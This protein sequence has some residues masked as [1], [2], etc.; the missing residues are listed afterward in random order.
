[1]IDTLIGWVLR[2][3]LAALGVWALLA[4]VRWIR[5]SRRERREAWTLR[6]A[7]GMV[8]LAAVYAAGHARLLLARESIEEGRTRYARFGDPRLAESNRAETRGWILDCSGEDRAALAR[9]AERGGVVERR[10]P[11]GQAGANLVGGGSEATERDFTVERLFAER[12]RRPRSLMES[13]ELHPAGTDL[14]LSLCAEPT[15]EAW[16]LLRGTGRPGTVVVQ[17]VG[18]GAL[19]AYAATGGPEQAPLGIKRYAPP[20]SVFKLALAALWWENGL[21]DT[22]LPCPA[23]IQVTPRAT[24]ANAGRAGYG[25]VEGP[26]GMLIPSCNTTAVIMAQRM[27]EQLGEEAFVQAYR[28]FGFGPYTGDAPRGADTAF[29][30]SGSDAWIRRMSPSLSRIRIGP[31]TGPAEW[32]QLAI[33]Q[34][35]VDVTPIAISR[36]VQAI[37]NGGVMLPPAL[38]W[39]RARK[40]PEGERV[41]SARTA[42]RLQRA[43]RGVVERGTG[44]AAAAQVRGVPGTLGG[45]TGTA[46]VRGAPDDGWFAGLVFDAEGRPRYT[47][48][49]YL[50]GGGPGGRA[51][52]QVAGGVARILLVGEG[53]R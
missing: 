5:D 33:G 40:A 11:L 19:V 28:R 15:R 37:G 34:G 35:P 17:D 51:P 21:P 46:Q 49:V 47:V 2:G 24:I 22:P 31:Q 23:E 38:E 13:G 3:I 14:R 39:E 43:M 41:M 27:R 1:M 32:A 10:Y 6:I 25:V 16:R 52:A 18:N 4:L 8:L 9:Y 29:W 44:R 50:Q 12:L 48:V 20:G 53:R 7:V 26:T 30:N 36:F 45:K 42:G